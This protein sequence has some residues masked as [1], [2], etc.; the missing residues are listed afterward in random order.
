MSCPNAEAGRDDVEN[1]RGDDVLNTHAA[2]EITRTAVEAVSFWELIRCRCPISTVS[3]L[4]RAH[5]HSDAQC[6]SEQCNFGCNPHTNNAI[7]SRTG[8]K[9]SRSAQSC[10]S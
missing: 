3:T 10:T 9:L 8:Q 2:A 4:D 7:F 6:S 1:R 5:P